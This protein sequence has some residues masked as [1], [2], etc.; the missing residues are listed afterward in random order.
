MMSF[1]T[2]QKIINIQHWATQN[3]V[4]VYF[5]ES[6][7]NPMLNLAIVFRAGSYYEGKNQGLAQLTASLL[8]QGAAG[9]NAGQIAEQF[10]QVGANFNS[11][12]GRDQAIVTLQTLTDAKYLQPALDLFES[13][14]T[15][16]DF[17]DDAVLRIKKQTLSAIENQQQTPTALVTLNFYQNLFKNNPYA[18]DPLGTAETISA[19]T[20]KQI[21]N[22]YQTHY[23]AKNA[24][25]A[26]VGDVSREQA[27]SIANQIANRLPAGQMPQIKSDEL[28]PLTGKNIS[29]KFA[30]EQTTMILGQYGITYADPN[31]FPLLLG[32]YV[33][34]GGGLVS[35][36][37][38]EVREKSGYTYRI[39]SQFVP[40]LNAG[41][42]YI[43]SQTR[44]DKSA[45]SEALIKKTLNNFIQTGVNEEQLTKAKQYL[46]G[47]FVLS[48]DSNADILNQIVKIGFYGLPLN[49][50]DQYQQNI[51]N[52]TVAQVN[53]AL[54]NLLKPDQMI[55]VLVGE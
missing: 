2:E 5:V 55:T 24:M 4:P 36:L 15:Q 34:G 19:I 23:V 16:P 6:R 51:Q 11:D 32:N 33:L 29:V 18:Q 12:S 17:N 45:E 52:V 53:Q 46:L 48:I 9:L 28:P 35:T 13:V 20:A 7:G 25:I 43:F 31:Y 47:S 44:K 37:F 22:F 50:L 54:K 41:V 26:L 30:G 49:Y 40:Y 38:K 27:E 10:D 8:D 21:K 39:N 1:A 14:L 3:G 42:F